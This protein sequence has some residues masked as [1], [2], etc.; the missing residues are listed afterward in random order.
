VAI[1]DERFEWLCNFHKPA[2]KVCAYLQ[3]W[4]IAGLVKGAHAGQGLGNAFLSNINAVDGLF[5]VIRVFEDEEVTHVEGNVDPVRDLEIISDELRLKDIERLNA[6][7]DDLEAKVRRAGTKVPKDQ[8]LELDCLRKGLEFLEKEKKAIRCC[9]WSNQEI[10]Y[11]NRHLLLTAK[12]VIYLVNMTEEDYIKKKNKWLPKIKAWIDSI[13][14]GMLIPFTAGLEAKIVDLEQSQGPEAVEKYLKDVGATSALPKI[15]KAGYSTL[16]LIYFF[17]AGEDEVK[18]WNI[19]KGTLAP[20]A[21]GTIHTDF[22][23]GFICAEIMKYDEF[24]ELGSELAVKAAGKY[25]QKGRDYVVEDGDIIFFKFNAPSQG[26][27]KK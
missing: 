2:S 6:I 26:G 20:Q 24:K 18:C 23:K 7:I 4:D 15:V 3:V 8:R 9:D 22:E 21:A 12:P 1:P 17:T 11:L 16:Q 13:D 14:G 25:K 10:E 19:R 5:H 27:K